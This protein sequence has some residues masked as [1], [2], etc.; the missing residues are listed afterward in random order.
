MTPWTKACEAPLSMGFPR[1]WSGL[2][3]PPPGNLPNWPRDQTHISCTADRSFTTEPPGKPQIYISSISPGQ[4]TNGPIR[5][6]QFHS[7]YEFANRWVT[8]TDTIWQITKI[9]MLGNQ[10][11]SITISETQATTYESHLQV[12]T[13][14]FTKKKKSLILLLRKIQISFKKWITYMLFTIIYFDVLVPDDLSHKE[15]FSRHWRCASLF[16]LPRG[17]LSASQVCKRRLYAFGIM[18]VNFFFF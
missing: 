4:R 11:K 18:L 9:N 8:G 13:Q 16:F 17:F 7:I 15:A 12:M 2:S 5:G 1:Y 6:F 3:F 14:N 10:D